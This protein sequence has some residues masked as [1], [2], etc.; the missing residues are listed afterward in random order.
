[1]EL[2][3]ILKTIKEYQNKEK[4]SFFVGAGVSK[5]SEFP[6]WAE[7]VLS[8]ADEI[9][10]SS[11]MVDKNGKPQLS[12]EEFLQIPQMYFNKYKNSEPDKYI[13][14]V[15]QQLNVKRKPN[16]IHKMIMKLNPYHLLTTNY[17][18]LLEQTANM[19]SINYSIINS[20]EKVSSA[21]TQR[22]I[23]KVHGDF[24]Q[25]NFVLKEQDY[26]DYEENF[27]LIDNVVKTIMATNLIVFIGYQLSD[28]NIKLILNW[29]QNVQGDSFIEPIFIY[30]D[31]EPLDENRIRY[32]EERKLHI[33]PAYELTEIDSYFERYKASLRAITE[34][35]E[36]ED[37]T[38][39]V[40]CIYN[41]LQP[42]DEMLYIRAND[43]ISL[44]PNYSVDK[45]NVIN[46]RDEEHDL[47]SQ[48]F[49]R[50]KELDD[51]TPEIV[52]KINY[53][54]DRLNN[55]G[56]NGCYA[57]N[58]T[59][60]DFAYNI[61]NDVF[62]V[63]FETIEVRVNS[64]GNSV[65][66]LYSKAYDLFVLGRLNESYYLYVSLLDKAKEENKWI[67]Y[68]F[69]QI[70]LRYLGHAIKQIN[71]FATGVQ[72]WL[73][74]HTMMDL[75]GDKL[76]EDINLNQAFF[77]LPASIKK[78]SFLERL[79][80]HNYYQ[81]DISKLY[82]MTYKVSMN[83]TN[84]S[85]TIIGA[86]EYDNT[87]ALLYDAVQFIYNNKILFDNYSEHKKFVVHTMHSILKGQF[88][89]MQ[90]QE[91]EKHLIR[92]TKESISFQGVLLM[93]KTFKIEDVRYL[94]KDS[95]DLHAFDF[96]EVD[97]LQFEA[98]I[99]KLMNYKNKNFRGDV[100]YD[101]M[102]MYILT[103]EEIK[104]MCCLAHYFVKSKNVLYKLAGFILN[105]MPDGELNCKQKVICIWDIIKDNGKRIDDEVCQ[106]IEK[107]IVEKLE[108]AIEKGD[109]FTGDNWDGS[110]NVLSEIVHECLPGYASEK[111]S[112]LYNEQLEDKVKKLFGQ[113]DK[114][115]A[116]KNR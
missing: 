116:E 12:S 85:V 46:Y 33:I 50:E 75:F 41:R 106:T 86:S 77:D 25:D 7:L 16:D 42:I 5:I 95:I 24:E 65:E 74:F 13:N 38:D 109:K 105:D 62:G 67:Y 53:I 83:A 48:Y 68:Y 56:I 57:K 32:Y 58:K 59:Y 18:T 28:Y 97:R 60:T 82:D 14:K 89:R 27:K 71:G 49:E 72:G 9:G 104:T 47:F 37:I 43:F 66:E 20:D 64:Y 84:K 2:Q 73:Y 6:S 94:E 63:D 35:K 69:V 4:L 108:Y 79:S 8:M 61:H 45:I 19:F 29:V 102:P 22:Y 1:M 15:S 40:T 34:Y 98:Y 78:L 115:F 76:L 88:E 70:N 51:L 11:Y 100:S 92:K 80:N 26:L 3:T 112:S 111:I 10:Y 36:D 113:C 96:L 99:S 17:D 110:I 30:T 103:K 107:Y 55:S 44:F 90:V 21:Q 114:I 87:E 101:K 39:C 93:M 81:E 91:D 23:V 52:N 54:H 31:P